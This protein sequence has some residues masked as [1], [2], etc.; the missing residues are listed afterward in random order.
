MVICHIVRKVQ[1][2]TGTSA[3]MRSSTKKLDSMLRIHPE[4]NPWIG[5]S[6]G[7]SAVHYAAAYGKYHELELLLLHAKKNHH[8][9][10]HLDHNVE[11]HL[12]TVI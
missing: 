8:D 4:L 6:S 1:V 9:P 11:N 2:S 5:D 7:W 12:P 3:S 10:H